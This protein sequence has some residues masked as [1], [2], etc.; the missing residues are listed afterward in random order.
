MTEFY[1]VEM[2]KCDEEMYV[3]ACILI[4]VLIIDFIVV[5]EY[6][7][8]IEDGIDSDNQLDQSVF[9]DVSPLRCSLS[10][11]TTAWVLSHLQYLYE[12]FSP[13]V[14]DTFTEHCM[15]FVGFVTCLPAK[16][17][18]TKLAKCRDIE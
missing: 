1:P 16:S 18:Y 7:R 9:V 11:F 13:E 14:F 3:L 5:M 6:N 2:K 17:I 12:D 10:F 15:C 4:C 8:P